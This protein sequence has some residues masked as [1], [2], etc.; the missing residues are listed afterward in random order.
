[1]STVA[2]S[3]LGLIEQ[4]PGADVIELAA[5]VG[6]SISATRSALRELQAQG[7]VRSESAG[8][9]RSGYRIDEAALAQQLS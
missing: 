8:V 1:M 3:L 4:R 9:E 2:R 5:V 6:A 7:I